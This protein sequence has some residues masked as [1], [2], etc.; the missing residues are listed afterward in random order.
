M[1]CR[2]ANGNMPTFIDVAIEFLL[3][4]A[5]VSWCWLFWSELFLWQFPIWSY[6][7]KETKR[8]NKV[9]RL[10]INRNNQQEIPDGMGRDMDRGGGVREGHNS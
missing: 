6:D 2:L 1:F 5:N 3:S 10:M 7:K 9:R 4:I 8:N